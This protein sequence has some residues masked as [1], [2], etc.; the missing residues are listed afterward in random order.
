LKLQPVDINVTPSA[1]PPPPKKKK[2]K[3]KKFNPLW[4]I[5]NFTPTTPLL[6]PRVSYPGLL[7]S[8]NLVIIRQKIK[9]IKH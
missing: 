6:P 7:K 5:F 2:E 8:R 3:K 4:A 9:K 1:P